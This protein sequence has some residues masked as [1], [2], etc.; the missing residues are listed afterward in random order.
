MPRE[1]QSTEDVVVFMGGMIRRGGGEEEVKS[2]K[3]K[4]KSGKEKE[5]NEK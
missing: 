4:V 1:G 5:G 2:E 3:R